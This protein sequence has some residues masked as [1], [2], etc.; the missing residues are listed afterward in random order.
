MSSPAS[1]PRAAA[2]PTVQVDNERVRV[3]EW[4]F[5]P[6]AETGWHRHQYPY[7]V[8]PLVDGVLRIVD[9]QGEKL[10]PLCVGA[11]YSRPAGIE[12]NVINHGPGPMAFVEI[13][14]K[15]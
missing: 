15:A 1:S 12:H 6:G 8:V 4:R 9:A 7:A 5:A 10:A 2:V 3:T 14:M 11:S 13:E